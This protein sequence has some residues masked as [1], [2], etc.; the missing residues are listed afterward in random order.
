MKKRIIIWLNTLLILGVFLV[1]TGSCEKDDESIGV[2]IAVDDYDIIIRNLYDDDHE[3]VFT[4]RIV[5]GGQTTSYSAF[6]GDYSHNNIVHHIAY[7]NIHFDNS[8][9][10]NV[11]ITIDII[12]N[13]TFPEDKCK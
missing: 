8:R 10:T 13:Y 5:N 7:T 3:V 11:D 9:V 2:C 4:A 12:D 6:E 1:L